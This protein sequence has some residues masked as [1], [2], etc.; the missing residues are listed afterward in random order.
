MRLLFTNDFYKLERSLAVFMAE[1]KGHEVVKSFTK[2]KPPDVLC[3]GLKESSLRKKYSR[4]MTGKPTKKEQQALA[5]NEEGADIVIV[6]GVEEFVRFILLN[7]VPDPD[8]ETDQH[9]AGIE[10]EQSWL[11]KGEYL[12]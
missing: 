10:T 8:P 4:D 3:V 6:R 7:E 5:A 2:S 11:K 12:E 9:R 1:T